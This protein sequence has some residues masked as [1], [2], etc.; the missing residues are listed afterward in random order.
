MYFL[1]VKIFD[2]VYYYDKSY[3]KKK[4][5]ASIVGHS[6]PDGSDGNIYPDLTKITSA[7]E[8]VEKIVITI[9]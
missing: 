3:S 8:I 6:S 2:K 4:F 9:N 1:T 5:N 7:L